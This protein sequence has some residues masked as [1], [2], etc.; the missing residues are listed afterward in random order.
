[1]DKPSC[2]GKFNKGWDVCL[3][4]CKIRDRCLSVTKTLNFQKNSDLKYVGKREVSRKKEDGTWETT[5]T[6]VSPERRRTKVKFTKEEVV[7]RRVIVP[8][9]PKPKTEL[10]YA[11]MS[12]DLATSWGV[13]HY[14]GIINGANNKTL[15]EEFKA[16]R[17]EEENEYV[18]LA[19]L[20]IIKE[21][22]EG[23]NK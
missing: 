11:A 9:P 21:E 1:M 4:V 16:I 8:P 7:K 2:F 13:F 17:K 12:A 22:L 20:A 3:S 6:F 15:V 5:T 10:K 18:K 23:R 19:R 14:R